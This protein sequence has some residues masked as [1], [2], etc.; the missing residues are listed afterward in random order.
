MATDDPDNDR[1]QKKYEDNLA[2]RFGEGGGAKAEDLQQQEEG[3][4]PPADSD[5]SSDKDDSDPGDNQEKVLDAEKNAGGQTWQKK[6][7]LNPRKMNW[8]KLT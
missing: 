6:T 3:G 1:I 8:F 7:K 4:T 5:E 2:G